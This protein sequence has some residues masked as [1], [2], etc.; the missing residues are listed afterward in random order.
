MTTETQRVRFTRNDLDEI[1]I[2]G[3]RET[4][5]YSEVDGQLCQWIELDVTSL[6]GWRKLIAV[7]IR[8]GG[9]SARRTVLVARD[10]VTVRCYAPALWPSPPDSGADLIV[11]CGDKVAVGAI[12]I[13]V[14]RPWT[15]YLLSDCCADDSWAYRDL[16]A[17]DRDDYR[18]TWAELT[19]SAE[20]SYNCPSVYQIARFFRYA[21]PE[22]VDRLACAFREGRFYVSPVPNQLLC[23]AF[24]LSAYPLILEPYR[25][26]CE[27]LDLAAARRQRAAYHMEA[28]T[29]TNGLVNLLAC[30]GF[31]L[32]GKSMLRFLSPWLD[33]LEDLP[34]L[35][36]LRVAPG[37]YVYLVQRPNTYSE[38]M[39]ILAGQ[40]Q[41]NAL[42]HG[43]SVPRHVALGSVH[44]TAAIPVVG[45]YSDL[46]PELPQV[47]AAKVRAV[48]EYN[49]QEWLYP[50]L[51]NGTWEQFADQVF[52]EAGDPAEP[53]AAGLRTVQGGTGSSWE[54]WPMA[55][56]AEQ[57]RFRRAQRAVVSART[58]D[59]M[60][61]VSSSAPVVAD[62]V[63]GAVLEVVELGDHAWNGA[64][65][66]SKQLNLSIRRNRLAKI[67]AHLA[68]VRAA[69][70]SPT[71]APCEG[72]IGVV[73]TLSW[74]RACRVNLPSGEDAHWVD[75]ATGEALPVYG[76]GGDRY[77]VVPDVPGYGCVRMQLRRR[78]GP[79]PVLPSAPPPDPVPVGGMAPLLITGDEDLTAN[80]GWHDGRRGRWT[81][82][83]F[84][85]K[86]R[87]APLA[88]GEGVE[89]CLDVAGTPPDEPYELRWLFDLPWN[90]VSWRGDS[91]GGFATPG[92]VDQGGDSLLGI[93][94]SIYACGEGLSAYSPDGSACV[95]F[96]FDQT[97]LCGLGGRMT[98][99][100]QGSYH[101]R[102]DDEVIRR[103]V[104]VSAHSP[105]RL[106]LYLLGTKQ[107]YREALLDQGGTRCWQMRCGMRRRS[108]SPGTGSQG[109]DVALYRFACA[110]NTPAELIDPSLWTHGPAWLSFDGGEHVLALGASREG[111]AQQG[112]VSID[113]Y[114]TSREP[115]TVTL[116]GPAL[117]ERVVVRADMLGRY[118]DVHPAEAAEVE[119][120]PLAYLKLIL[121]RP[122]AVHGL[123]ASATGVGRSEP[124]Q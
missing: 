59:A 115:A 74:T 61:G 108:L 100:A 40:P 121:V 36:R 71:D 76:S 117:G 14:Q 19:A 28:P 44:P 17:H 15:V 54:G 34:P 83:P 31:R 58:L 39:P 84:V 60:L 94:G 45:L 52:A 73:N 32:F 72:P 13:G 118:L 114:N 29:W 65:E 57:G 101:D 30:A 109:G 49:A 119:V 69:Y 111:D 99:A 5:F 112:A 4:I 48:D 120:G 35:T 87:L 67:D 20:N 16:E 51:V 23:G 22:Q 80:G 110:F 91:G 70:G 107:N 86:A 24:T 3:Y 98:R 123:P 55:A 63:R 93:V 103:S 102:F 82:G 56:Q 38:G 62:E 21:T 68:T 50:R 9:R 124:G 105:G 37:R 88:T 85:V 33:L 1:E 81:I 41:T 104:W 2:A 25:Y 116:R 47:S 78:P 7:E 77:A 79:L 53:F 106:E 95:D 6:A 96:A 90:E 11:T 46:A 27:R 10:P 8:S 42:L 43:E 26:W 66:A 64:F 89:L 97:G 122:D 113:L 12:E 18:T 92:P 75:P